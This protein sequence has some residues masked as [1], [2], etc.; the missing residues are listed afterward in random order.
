EGATASVGEEA[1]ATLEEAASAPRWL[2]DP[3]EDLIAEIEA[4]QR[5]ASH[6]ARFERAV[7]DAFAFLGFDTKWYGGAGGTDVIV[8]SPLGHD[9]F[10]ATVDTKASTARRIQDAQHHRR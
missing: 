3:L 8:D 5:D 10:R 1:D 2:S 4:A 7:A 9:R 6:S